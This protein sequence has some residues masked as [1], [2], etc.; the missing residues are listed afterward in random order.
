VPRVP[1]LIRV[2]SLACRGYT[3]R[4]RFR[5]FRRLQ[6]IPATCLSIDASGHSI[7]SPV[8]AQRRMATAACSLA[9]SE[10]AGNLRQ[11][12]G[13][14][15]DALVPAPEPPQPQA[16]HRFGRSRR[17]SALRPV[18]CACRCASLL[19]LRLPAARRGYRHKTSD[20]A[21]RGNRNRCTRWRRWL[22]RT[23]IFPRWGAFID[24]C[25]KHRSIF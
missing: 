16:G 25:E 22:P 10:T 24:K 12:D 23:H 15:R 13:W 2:M 9:Q 1:S 11:S 20:A 3:R 17:A 18:L 8:S 6:T 7:R 14:L 21:P 5:T 4:R 19:M